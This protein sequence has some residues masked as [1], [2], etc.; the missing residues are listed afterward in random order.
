MDKQSSL[1][2]VDETKHLTK[3][4]IILHLWSQ[5]QKIYNKFA[6][7]SQELIVTR[8]RYTYEEYLGKMKTLIYQ[9]VKKIHDIDYQL[10]KFG[11]FNN[12]A[13]RGFDEKEREIISK[14]KHT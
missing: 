6:D 12:H 13:L 1:C 10:N 3:D 2:E 4:F 5:R 9:Y 7:D 14:Y 8:H 11:I